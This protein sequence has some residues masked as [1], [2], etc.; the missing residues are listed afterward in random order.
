M[1]LD[2]EDKQFR[3]TD[4]GKI[5]FQP[6]KTNPVPGTAV[7]R[8]SKGD[9]LF[10]PHVEIIPEAFPETVDAGAGRDKIA[11]WLTHHIETI[12]EP[13]KLLVQEEGID[14]P[15]KA[16]AARL[17]EGLGILPRDDLADLIAEL[18]EV[19]R[20]ALRHRRVR[21]G[22]VLV[23]LPTLNKPAAVHLRALLWSLW[24]DKPLPAPVPADGITSLSLKDKLE[25]ADPLFYRSVGYPLYGP[26]A[27]RV[28]MLDRLISAVYDSAD[29]GVFKAEHKMAEW[30]GCPIADLYE[31]LEAM[32]HTKIS[33]PAEESA[34]TAEVSSEAED[35][36]QG[37]NE[38]PASGPSEEKSE[39]KPEAETPATEPPKPEL[40]I[41][42]LKR[43]HK[44]GGHGRGERSFKNKERD[45]DHKAHKSTH[46]KKKPYKKDHKGKGGEPRQRVYSVAAPESNPDDSPFAVLQQLKGQK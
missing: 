6:D 30:L 26:R 46:K 40:A 41:F 38:T 21:L 39:E 4:D 2:A 12:L 25:E 45:K 35:A 36:S 32:G 18:D 13:L 42:R 23:F 3:L 1:L 20:G 29:K 19:G 17:Y 10:T 14:G 22:P 15:A 8:V 34:E 11:A 5:L 43:A 7:A 27:V 44:A 31:V 24:N 9:A 33:D 16:I 28:D 37:A